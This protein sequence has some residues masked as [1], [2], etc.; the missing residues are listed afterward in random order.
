MFPQKHILADKLREATHVKEKRLVQ[1]ARDYMTSL[2]V[3]KR[4]LE[5]L[6]NDNPNDRKQLETEI[7][8]IGGATRPSLFRPHRHVDVDGGTEMTNM[9]RRRGNPLIYRGR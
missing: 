3:Y 9:H 1:T 2:T 7:D 6:E 5:E 8:L 4:I